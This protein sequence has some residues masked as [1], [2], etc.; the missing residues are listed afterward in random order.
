MGQGQ[1]EI[2][3]FREEGRHHCCFALF[4]SKEFRGPCCLLVYSFSSPH[5]GRAGVKP[6]YGRPS[7]PEE[8]E[9]TGGGCTSQHLWPPQDASPRFI[10]A[11]PEGTVDELLTSVRPQT[12]LSCAPE[13]TTTNNKQPWNRLNW[14]FCTPLNILLT[15]SWRRL[16]LHDFLLQGKF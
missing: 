13:I 15:L 5:K 16:D 1:A 9:S 4:N 7:P 6:P 12:P 14:S 8:C 3:A 2:R 10:N 11:V